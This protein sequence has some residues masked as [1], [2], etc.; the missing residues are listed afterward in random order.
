MVSNLFGGEPIEY[1]HDAV[2]EVEIGGATVRDENAGVGTQITLSFG[3]RAFVVDAVDAIVREQR[4]VSLGSIVQLR[5]I[6][7]AEI[8]SVQGSAHF[9]A[10]R[11][12]QLGHQHRNIFIEQFAEKLGFRTTRC[13][14]NT[15]GDS[16]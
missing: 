6:G 13:C 8:V 3:M 12:Q 15:Q 7:I 14:D 11:T 4:P 16:A 2:G 10:V 9:E 5:C 1:G